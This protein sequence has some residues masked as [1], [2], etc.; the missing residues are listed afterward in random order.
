[1]ATAAVM[2]PTVMA[3]AIL[4]PNPIDCD[5]LTTSKRLLNNE[6]WGNHKRLIGDEDIG[7]EFLMELHLSRI[8]AESLRFQTMTTP[9]ANMGSVRDCERPP[10]Y[11]SCLG[12]K[13]NTPPAENCGTF[14]RANPC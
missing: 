12:E 8:L 10:R 3:L 9:N 2:I 5:A 6:T 13:R 4:L 11:D 14:N 1:M 7:S